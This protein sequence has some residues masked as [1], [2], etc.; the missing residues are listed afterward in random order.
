MHRSAHVECIQGTVQSI[1]L[2]TLL[3]DSSYCEWLANQANPGSE[4]RVSSDDNFC[5]DLHVACFYS[6][7]MRPVG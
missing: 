7:A 4:L 1:A 5:Y 2:L 6:T 3:V